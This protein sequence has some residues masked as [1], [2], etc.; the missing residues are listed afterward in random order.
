LASLTGGAAIVKFN[1]T[2]IGWAE[3]ISG[4]LNVGARDLIALIN[5]WGLC[6]AQ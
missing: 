3:D 1:A 2:P 5:A 4:D 6:L